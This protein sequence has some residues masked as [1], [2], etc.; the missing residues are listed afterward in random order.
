MPSPHSLDYSEEFFLNYGGPGGYWFSQ[1]LSNKLHDACIKFYGHPIR[2]VEYNVKG[3]SIVVHTYGIHRA[4]HVRL[5]KDATEETRALFSKVAKKA[6]DFCDKPYSLLGNNCATSVSHVLHTIDPRFSS[7]KTVLPWSLDQ[8][9]KHYCHSENVEVIPFIEKYHEKI[10][11]DKFSFFRKSHWGGKK[12]ESLNEI[13]RHV[14]GRGEYKGERTRST[15][16]E[17]GWI[18]LGKNGECLPTDKAPKEFYQGLN[19][20][21]EDWKKVRELKSSYQEEAGLLSRNFRKLFGDNPDYETAKQ[22]LIEQAQNNPGGA[23][24]KVIAKFGIEIPEQTE[25]KSLEL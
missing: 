3:L 5:P 24:S 22:R 16:L 1:T 20:F 14:Y 10:R 21:N 19:T 12:I 17:M 7:G 15:L 2:E 25:T 4:L 11:E 18:T 13:V 9:L 6:W 23:S 8:D